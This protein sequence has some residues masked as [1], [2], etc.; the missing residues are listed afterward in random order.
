MIESIRNLYNITAASIDRYLQLNGWTRNQNF[1]NKNL[2][3]YLNSHIKLLLYAVCKKEVIKN[4]NTN[5]IPI[6]YKR[7]IL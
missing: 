2:M 7:R 4:E 6:S 3:V 5:R 1:A